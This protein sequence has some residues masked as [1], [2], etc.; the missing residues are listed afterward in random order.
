MVQEEETPSLA[1]NQLQQQLNYQPHKDFNNVSGKLPRM[2][3]LSRR[4]RKLFT[5]VTF[6]PN[7][8]SNYQYV[9]ILKFPHH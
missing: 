5:S 7:D 4:K 3:I 9:N 8:T 2:V 1:Q 6:D